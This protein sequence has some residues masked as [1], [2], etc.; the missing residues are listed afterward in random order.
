MSVSGAQGLVGYLLLDTQV[1]RLV[2]GRGR[3]KKEWEEERT[4]GNLVMLDPMEV[5]EFFLDAKDLVDIGESRLTFRGK[6]YSLDPTLIR[7]VHLAPCRYARSQITIWATFGASTC[8]GLRRCAARQH[9]EVLEENLAAFCLF[10]V[11][12]GSRQAL[13]QLAQSRRTARY[14]GGPGHQVARLS[15]QILVGDA[16]KL[17]VT[18]LGL[19]PSADR[20]QSQVRR[21]WRRRIL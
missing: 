8:V 15:A 16:T 9:S 11:P 10:D 18:G 5:A 17:Q 14:P 4:T 12:S 1:W 13:N 20:D 3:T 21:R 7:L 19:Q 6:D 2:S